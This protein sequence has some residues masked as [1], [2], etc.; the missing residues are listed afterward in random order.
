MSA[1]VVESVDL[2]VLSFD[3]NQWKP[4]QFKF[5]EVSNFLEARDVHCKKP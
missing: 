5:E 4:G 1:Y 2:T 3:E